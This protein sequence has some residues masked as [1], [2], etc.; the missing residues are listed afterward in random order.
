VYIYIYYLCMWYSGWG[1]CFGKRS[2]GEE[3]FYHKESSSLS[4]MCALAFFFF[5]LFFKWV[6]W[7][8]YS[9]IHEACGLC[10]MYSLSLSWRKYRG[11]VPFAFMG[12][13]T[14]NCLHEYFRTRSLI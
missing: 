13:G 8:F 14:V 6:I 5:F 2:F 9:S 7:R 3:T 1:K 10:V 4:K 11:P 12:D